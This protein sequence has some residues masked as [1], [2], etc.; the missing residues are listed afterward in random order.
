[1]LHESAFTGFKITGIN[2]NK[3][4]FPRSNPP[5][6]DNDFYLVLGPIGNY[7]AFGNKFDKEVYALWGYSFSLAVTPRYERG[8]AIPKL[9]YIP[10]KPKRIRK[11]DCGEIRVSDANLS[12]IGQYASEIKRLVDDA[13]EGTR[14]LINARNRTRTEIDI[15]NKESFRD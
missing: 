5:A 3:L 13:N 14:A 7:D 15:I 9:E 2:P 6:Q 1:M 11:G 10:D 4:P 12:S 8:D